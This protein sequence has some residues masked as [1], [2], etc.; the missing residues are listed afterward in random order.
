MIQRYGQ[1]SFFRKGSGTKWLQLD[2]NLQSQTEI[3][4]QPFS[5]TGLC[6]HSET[7]TWHDMIRTYGLGLVSPTH[8]IYMFSQEKCFSCN[9]PLFDQLSLSGQHVY[10]NCLLTKLWRHKIWYYTDLSNQTIF[11]HDQKS[12]QKWKY[13]DSEKNIWGEMKSIFHH[14]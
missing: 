3:N 4:T 6:I 10:Y 5:Q 13:L 2:S 14:F 7:R 1:F 8:Y 12:W 9:V 11:L